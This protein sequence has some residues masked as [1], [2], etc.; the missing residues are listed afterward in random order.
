MLNF[1]SNFMLGRGHVTAITEDSSPACW[2][3]H[4]AADTSRND[5]AADGAAAKGNV[6][7]A[8]ADCA[9]HA[10]APQARPDR[11]GGDAHAGERASRTVR[12]QHRN[13]HGVALLPNQIQSNSAGP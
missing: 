6:G 4:E 13:P 3:A 10:Q 12:D 5:P 9:R 7:R 11:A 2:A 8:Q 1:T